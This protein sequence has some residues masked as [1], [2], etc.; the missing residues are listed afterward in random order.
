ML[1]IWARIIIFNGCKVFHDINMPKFIY[2]I[3][4]N[5]SI[6]D[7]K[8]MNFLIHLSLSI[9]LIISLGYIL[10]M[11]YCKIYA[12]FLMLLKK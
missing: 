11:E 9:C 3:I 10:E 4:S 5:F 8:A 7:T 12:H 6:T 2:L 1:N